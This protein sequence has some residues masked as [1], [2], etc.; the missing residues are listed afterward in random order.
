MNIPT[1]VDQ[2]LDRPVKIDARQNRRIKGRND[3]QH[4]RH[5]RR[6]SEKMLPQ[7]YQ[8][9]VFRNAILQH[10][11]RNSSQTFI[12]TTALYACMLNVYIYY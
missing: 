5:P 6:R 7:V 10:D 8:Q 2:V 12:Y 1:S 3:S 9:D 4:T 11:Y